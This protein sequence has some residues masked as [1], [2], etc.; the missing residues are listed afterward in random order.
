MSSRSMSPMHL[1]V[2]EI[3]SATNMA[4]HLKLLLN[5]IHVDIDQDFIDW[6]SRVIISAGH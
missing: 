5:T 2:R 4:Q 1:T 3:Q 6:L